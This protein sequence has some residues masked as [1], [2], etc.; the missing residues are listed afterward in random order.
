MK[1][2]ASV[3]VDKDCFKNVK[4]VEVD[5]Q[6]ITPRTSEAEFDMLNMD[7]KEKRLDFIA[8]VEIPNKSRSTVDDLVALHEVSE[9]DKKSQKSSQ[10]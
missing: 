3:P 6:N 4:K 7:S 2:A 1:K 10:K 9:P 8:S 5:I